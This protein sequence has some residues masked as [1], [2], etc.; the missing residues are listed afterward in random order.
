MLVLG[1]GS[2]SPRPRHS[3]ASAAGHPGFR[4]RDVLRA[5]SRADATVG[6][7]M[8]NRGSTSGRPAVVG[9][10]P[11][12]SGCGSAAGN[13]CAGSEPGLRERSSVDLT[14]PFV[15]CRPV[16]AEEVDEYLRG[17][18]EP[19]RSTLQALR[20]TILE[21]VPDAEQVISYR[22]PAFRVAERPSPALQRSRIT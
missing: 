15:D 21:I 11:G 3:A 20:R 12:V 1:R 18:D 10:A 9:A 19:K 7:A 13:T 22:V 4:R 2:A 14:P 5:P 16:S 8:Q 17:L 6:C